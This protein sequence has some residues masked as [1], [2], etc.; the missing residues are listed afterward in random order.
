MCCPFLESKLNSTHLPRPWQEKFVFQG[1]QTPH[2]LGENLIKFV[3]WALSGC[4]KSSDYISSFLVEALD[5]DVCEG[6]PTKKEAYMFWDFVRNKAG[7]DDGILNDLLEM[8]SRLGEGQG[9]LLVLDEFDR[10]YSVPDARSYYFTIDVLCNCRSYD[11]AWSMCEE[12]LGLG[13]LPEGEEVGSIISW[14][15]RGKLAKSVRALYSALKEELLPPSAISFLI[16]SLSLEHETVKLARKML[17]DFNEGARRYAIKPFS[18]VISGLC[19]SKDLDGAK[20]FL[21]EMI[22][23]GPPPGNVVYLMRSFVS[24]GEMEEAKKKHKKLSPVMYP[25]L[26]RGYC[27]LEDFDKALELLREMK[28]FGFEPDANGY[29]KLIQSLHLKALD[30]ETTEKL[31]EETK[32]SRLYLNGTTRGPVRAVKELEGERSRRLKKQEQKLR[33][34]SVANRS[35]LSQSDDVYSFG[36]LYLHE[37]EPSNYFFQLHISMHLPNRSMV[38]NFGC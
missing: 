31:M 34:F 22:E 16:T 33:Q 24:D 12:M 14:L 9:A 26:S 18:V 29:S 4:S 38:L 30:K 25:T 2:I 37:F 23:F 21:H 6:N 19:W 13:T 10:Y 32:Q 15:C 20:K 27:K 36:M 28:S 11:L 17:G 7:L 1:L 3:Q 5:Q 35:N 8:F